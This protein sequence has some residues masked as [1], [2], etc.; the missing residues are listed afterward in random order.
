MTTSPRRLSLFVQTVYAQLLDQLRDASPVG[1]RPGSFVSKRVQGKRYWYLQRS[2]NGKQKQDYIGP[3]SDELSRLIKDV[4][5]GTQLRKQLSKM[6]SGGGAYVVQ[7]AHRKIL[8]LLADAGVFRLGAVLIGAHAFSVYGNMLGVKWDREIVATQDIDVAQ[9]CDL[10]VAVAREASI[11]LPQKLEEWKAMTLLPV[12]PSPLNPTGTVT[13]FRDRDSELRLELLTPMKG[14]ERAGSIELPHLNAAAQPLRFL[15]YLIE[16]PMEAAV[17]GGDGVLV[18]IPQPSRFALH[19]LIVAGRR[20]RKE[21]R[22]KHLAHAA[23]L[24]WVL[25]EEEPDELALAWRTLVSRGPAW[26][27]SARK[28]LAKLDS[29]LRSRLEEILG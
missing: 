18:N 24:C 29:A 13:S 10:K 1:R 16:E 28:S 26:E 14:R 23:S 5:A 21:K 6:A 7:S 4:R 3:D 9:D 17:V 25:L 20:T 2:Q 15:D 22:R 11:D 19:K 27:K 8:E 12:P